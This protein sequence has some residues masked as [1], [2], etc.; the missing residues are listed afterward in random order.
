MMDGLEQV[1]R[2][3]RAVIS[4]MVV[5]ILAGF[6]C[7]MSLAK[8]ARPDIQ[9]P[10]FY[11]S[12]PLEGVSPED[13]ER[14]LVKPME[15]KLRGLE[16]LKELTSIAAQ[17]HAAIITEFETEIDPEIAS[18]KVREKVDEAKGELP[19]DAKEPTVNEVNFSLFPTIIVALSGDVPERTLFRHAR[20]LQDELEAL[21]SVLEANLSG[22]REELLEININ[23]KALESYNIDQ[24]ELIAS[25]A[26]NN[27]LVAAGTF[28]GGSGRFNIKVP[29]LFETA[30][31]IYSLPIKEVNGTVVKLSEV[32]EI[33][34]S[35]KDRSV[36]AR[37]NGRP[38]ITISVVKRQG[39]N[40][41]E[42]NELVRSTA[43]KLVN[44]WPDKVHVDFALDESTNIRE[45]V[46]SLE[47]AIMTAIALVMIVCVAALGMRSAL[48][49][50]MAIP[51]SFMIGFLIVFLQGNTINNMLMFGMVLTVGMLVDGAI[52]IVEYADRKMAEGLHRREAYIMAAR[53]M[54]WPIASSTATTLAAFLPMLFWPGI[55]GKFMSNLPTTVVI[56]L[57]ASLVTAMVFLPVLGSI[58][59]KTEQKD[60]TLSK[61][62][63]GDKA[64]DVSAIKGATGLYVRTLS[65]LVRAPLVVTVVAFAA[66]YG[67][68]DFYKNNNHGVTFFVDTEPTQALIYVRARGNLSANEKLSLTR[69]V[70]DIVLSIKGVDDV[71]VMTGSTGTGGRF[72]GAGLDVPKD[73]IGQL[74]V[75][76][77]PYEQRRPGNV[78]ITE[79]RDKVTTLP[80]VIVEVKKRQD[81]PQTGKDVRLQVASENR[82]LANQIARRIRKHME[83]NME[84][85]IDVEDE[86]P[87]PGIEWSLSINREEAG[88]FGADI[89]SVGALIQMVTDG[90]L[91]G[92]YRPDDSRDEID[93][94][95]RLPEEQRELA[96]LED[97][98]LQ[99]KKGLVP[100]RNFVEREAR[101]AVNSIT[102]KDGLTSVF[103]K[104]NAAPGFLADDK[105]KELDTWI[106]S[107]KWP[108]GVTLKFRGADEEQRESMSFLMKAV[109]ASIFIMFMILV[110]QF[111]SFYHTAITLSTVVMSVIGVLIGMLV[112]KQPF[113]VIMT[114]TG[115]V[116]LAGIVVNNSIVL[117]DTFHNLRDRGLDVVDAVLRSCAQRLRP[118]LLTTITTIFGLLPMM[119]QVNVDWFAPSISIGSVT[120]IWWVQLSTAII[121]G[122]GFSTML[123]LLLTPV[124]IAAPTIYKER[125]HALRDWMKRKPEEDKDAPEPEAEEP[126]AEEKPKVKK[127]ARK[128][129]RKP[130]PRLE[131][132][133]DAAE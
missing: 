133:P 52:V 11:I 92:T 105:V 47:S 129:R 103:V 95:A 3:P 121:F 94:R 100:I 101:P 115:V 80:G 79:I 27:R 88:R 20:A 104:A 109:A 82:E 55:P 99:T 70:E 4:L 86:S 71:A 37:F 87:L 96:R 49:V 32:A 84:G 65:K 54:F 117:I 72:T 50:G 38:A 29:G 75:E 64:A 77:L 17:G 128:P 126:E 111:N 61:A 76:L 124:W 44:S 34:R 73:A 56:V 130:K 35:F 67:V 113:S 43:R 93:I 68:I 24:T 51:T 127:P 13:A 106:K 1:L 57:S 18:R 85:L 42:T 63:A 16:G 60:A 122:L 119:Y 90:V 131:P 89:T 21:P 2:R 110:T 74:T 102:R 10:T 62:L 14:L 41:I 132:V 45:T 97:L 12:I 5:M 6:F 81:G 33:R 30:K 22:Q 59:G 118:V 83:N 40:I 26:R 48:L 53:R 98:R 15:E 39:E 31:D 9:V 78:I 19:D 91:I 8:E 23:T 28:D 114:G 123:T 108:E 112:M 36:Y 69:K 66:M 58:F 125:W 116:A 25:V 120:S 107:Q 46:G 7:Y